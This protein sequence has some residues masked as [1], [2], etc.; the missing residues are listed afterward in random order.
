MTEKKEKKEKTIAG[1]IWRWWKTSLDDRIQESGKDHIFDPLEE[2][3][4]AKRKNRAELK[5]AAS[6][7]E[8][9][10]HPATHS[11]YAL[12]CPNAEDG[13]TGIAPKRLALI[14]AVLAGVE[15]P[16]SGTLPA[17]FGEKTHELPALSPLRFQRIIRAGDDWRLAVL[18]RRALPLVGK[19]CNVASLG[20]DLFH[21]GEDVRIRWCFDYYRAP[22]PDEL[23]EPTDT[24]EPASEDA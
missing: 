5:H 8:V 4:G 7:A 11:L 17:R 6:P 22:P 9:L 1:Q 10:A 19:R 21:W 3:R 12:L 14:A 18:L 15:E 24:A 23:A 13:K 2:S 20:S 16:R